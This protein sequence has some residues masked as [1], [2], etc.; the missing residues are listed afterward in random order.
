[1]ENCIDCGKQCEKIGEINK[2]GERKS[3][4]CKCFYKRDKSFTLEIW[5]IHCHAN[6]KS[7]GVKNGNTY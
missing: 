2:K 4:C 7:E 6:R 1:M 5:C 3:Y